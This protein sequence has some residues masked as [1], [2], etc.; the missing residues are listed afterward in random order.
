M[1]LHQ[2]TFRVDGENPV[3]WHSDLFVGIYILHKWMLDCQKELHIH[4][5]TYILMVKVK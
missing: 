5:G 4:V 1:L 3:Q 2:F